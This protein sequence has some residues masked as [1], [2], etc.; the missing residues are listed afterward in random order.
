MAK[1]P[2][3]A[4]PKPVAAAKKEPTADGRIDALERALKRVDKRLD[5]LEDVNALRLE[6]RGYTKA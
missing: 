4:S 3:A 1:T 2:E 6:N 5:Q